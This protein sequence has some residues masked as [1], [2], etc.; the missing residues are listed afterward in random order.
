M[1][2]ACANFLV[3]WRGLCRGKMT[4]ALVGAVIALAW[5]APLVVRTDGTA[6]GLREMLVR[7]QAGGAF[8]VVFVAVL[9]SSC[10]PSPQSRVTV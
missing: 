7:L 8:A 3:A 10:T 5:G 2:G 1:K 9:A 6:A 4:A